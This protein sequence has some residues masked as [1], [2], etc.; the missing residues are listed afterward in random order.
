MGEPESRDEERLR[1]KKRRAKSEK[2]NQAVDDDDVDGD[3]HIESRRRREKTRVCKVTD[4]K[5]QADA[6]RE[7]KMNKVLALARG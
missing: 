7:R 1:K 4:S 2:K 6:I 5:S 3:R